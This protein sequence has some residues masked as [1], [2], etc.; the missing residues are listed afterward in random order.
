M[1]TA[2]RYGTPNASRFLKRTA[3]AEADN[4]GAVDLAD[5]MSD[6]FRTF[7]GNL[8]A[9]AGY[10]VECLS[11]MYGEPVKTINGYLSESGLV[12]HEAACRNCDQRKETF[13][14]SPSS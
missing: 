5:E 1:L 9:G 11:Q 13:R 4:D 12:G 3:T 2:T 7:L 6:L 10:C 14:A 8:S